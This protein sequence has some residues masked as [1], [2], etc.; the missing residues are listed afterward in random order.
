MNNP[1]LAHLAGQIAQIQRMERG[2][3][4]ILREGPEGPYYKLQA[5]E[6][7][8]NLSRYIPAHQADAVQQ[9]IDGYRQFKE[10]TDDYAQGVIARTRQELAADSKKNGRKSRRTSSWPKTR[11]SSS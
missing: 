2:K 11:K 6:D 3:L 4:S 7:G 10:L 1:N 9:A 8:K 5:W